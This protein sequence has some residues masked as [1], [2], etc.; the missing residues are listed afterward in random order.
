MQFTQTGTTPN[1]FTYTGEQADSSGLEYLRVRY[2]DNAT[3][4]FV[5]KDPLPLAQR[6]F[7]F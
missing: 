5:A 3:G 4:R 7:L 2:Y 6:Y 1:E